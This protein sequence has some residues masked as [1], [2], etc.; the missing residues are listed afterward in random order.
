MKIF[1][2]IKIDK[3]WTLRTVL[4]VIDPKKAHFGVIFSPKTPPCGAKGQIESKFTFNVSTSNYIPNG[5]S[6][7]GKPEKIE[8]NDIWNHL[9]GKITLFLSFSGTYS[10]NFNFLFQPTNFTNS[11]D[12]TQNRINLHY[13]NII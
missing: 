9:V 7:R 4:E 5:S 11:R 13:N 12:M 2:K 10:N 3:T 6:W 1:K 8:L